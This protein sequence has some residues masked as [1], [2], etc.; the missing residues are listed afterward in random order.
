MEGYRS[1]GEIKPESAR[2]NQIFGQSRP[3]EVDHA[4][5]DHSAVNYSAVNYSAVNY[6]AFSRS[7]GKGRAPLEISGLAGSWNHC[8]SMVA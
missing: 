5:V 7:T 6:S 1:G 2:T 8:C 3:L 4:A